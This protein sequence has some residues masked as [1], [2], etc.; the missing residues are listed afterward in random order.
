MRQ[1]IITVLFLNCLICFCP[2]KSLSAN[3]VCSIQKSVFQ[4]TAQQIFQE[5]APATK[6]IFKDLKK[7]H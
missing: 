4:N 2:L 5:Q 7:I 6:D 1:I 3:F